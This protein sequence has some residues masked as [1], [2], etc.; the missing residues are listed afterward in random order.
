MLIASFNNA[1]GFTGLP[2][3]ARAAKFIEQIHPLFIKFRKVTALARAL[4][5]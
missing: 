1:R 4:L 2:C 3:K 5:E